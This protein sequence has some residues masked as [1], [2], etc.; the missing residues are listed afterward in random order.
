MRVISYN[1]QFGGLGRESHIAR[2]L[3]SIEPD[4]VVLQ[5]AVNTRVVQ[6]IAEA[7]RMPHW[8]AR[9]GYSLALMSRL[10]VSECSWV[11]PRRMRHAFL[12]IMVG[13]LPIFGVHL[14]PYF[15]RWS[16]RQR[17]REVTSLLQ[18]AEPYRERPHLLLGDFN[19][20]SPLD[21]VELRRMPRWIRLMIRVGAGQIATT[22]IRAVMDN[23]YLDSY[24]TLYPDQPGPTLPSWSPHIR[25]DYAFLPKQYRECLTESSVVKEGVGQASDHCPLVT[26]LAV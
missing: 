16:E 1:I 15:S 6:S 5:E 4:V 18:L 21:V 25:L 12:R 13:E 14:Q 22:A 24:R 17:V 26:V 10:P 2:V 20:I 19:A 3:R 23:D 9:R 11:R 8:Y 7:A